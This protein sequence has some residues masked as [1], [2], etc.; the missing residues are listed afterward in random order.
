MNHREK[1]KKMTEH[2]VKLIATEAAQALIDLN[3]KPKPTGVGSIL[4]DEKTGAKY[5]V[6]DIEEEAIRSIFYVKP[7]SLT[8]VPLP[9]D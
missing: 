3:N 1:K 6:T 5:I 9:Q 2:E 8:V 7:K 4:V